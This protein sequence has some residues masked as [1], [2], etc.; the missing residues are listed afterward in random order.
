MSC[1]VVVSKRQGQNC[2]MRQSSDEAHQ[3]GDGRGWVGGGLLG[4]MGWAPGRGN[5]PCSPTTTTTPI[6]S[7]GKFDVDTNVAMTPEDRIYLV[8]WY[9]CTSDL[10]PPPHGMST[11][12][13]GTCSVNTWK[14]DTGSF[15]THTA[16]LALTQS[17]CARMIAIED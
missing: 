10:G 9:L 16:T 11:N 17:H 2:C 5:P 13:R 4:L 15:L 12:T 14:R 1:I 8:A 7:N 3:G 6:R